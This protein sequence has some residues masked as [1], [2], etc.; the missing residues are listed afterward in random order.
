MVFYF[1]QWQKYKN[2]LTFASV[3][4]QEYLASGVGG[5]KNGILRA[6]GNPKISVKAFVRQQPGIQKVKML[7]EPMALCEKDLPPTLKH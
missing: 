3:L 7:T 4:C 2:S 6:E 5:R 1:E